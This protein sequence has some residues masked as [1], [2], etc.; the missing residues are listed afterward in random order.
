MYLSDIE[1][2]VFKISQFGDAFSAIVVIQGVDS[3]E[4]FTNRSKRMLLQRKNNSA[5]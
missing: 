3:N 2:L 1:N 4:T 5:K